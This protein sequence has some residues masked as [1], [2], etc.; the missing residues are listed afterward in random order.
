MD[1]ALSNGDFLCDSRGFPVQISGN[2]EL[3]QQALIRI[4]VRNG[5]FA[6]NRNLG[7]ELYKL[8]IYSE[9]VADKAKVL[10][11][12]A[13]NDMKNVLVKDVFAEL[14]EDETNLILN[15]TLA[16]NGELKDVVITI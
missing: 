15:I 9:N 7:S 16:L 3:L 1:T 14:S 12:E 2:D 13:L 5:S 4:S 6:Y 11:E 10:I 8:N